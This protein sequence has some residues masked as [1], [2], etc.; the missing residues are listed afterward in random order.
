[1]GGHKMKDPIGKCGFNCSRCGSYKENLKTNEDRQRI[2]DGWHKYFGFRMD[3]QTLLRCDGCQVPQEEKP[4][5]YINCRIRRCAV[6]NGIKTCANCPAYP[7]EEVKVNSSGHTREKVETRLGNPMPEEEYLAFVEPYQGVKHLEEIRA[8]LEPED[9]VEMTKVALRPRIV[10][11]PENLPFSRKETS[12]FE[13]L[14]RTITRVESADGISYAR[15]E[16]L[17]KRRRHLLKVLWAAGLHGELKKKRGLHLEIDSET[18]LAEKIQSSYSKAKDYFKALEKYGVHCEHVPLKKEGWLT[19]EGSLRK[20][21]W[22]MK[23]SF[24]DDAGGPGT[25]RALQKYTT[26]LSKK[27]GKNAFRYFSK[28]DMRV[29]SN[30]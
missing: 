19:P 25:L 14:H 10:D 21:N 20:G 27:H 11:F 9:I 2:S 1:M 4:I 16:V 26:K 30:G 28:A 8:S 17:K 18:Y 7:C 5:R 13:A 23:M 22:Y 6:Y 24:G 15:R 12:A 29:L 3:P